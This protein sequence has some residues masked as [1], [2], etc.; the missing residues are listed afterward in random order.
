MN[1]LLQ[2]QLGINS[3]ARA[4]ALRALFLVLPLLALADI[5]GAQ[6]AQVPLTSRSLPPPPPNVMVTIDDSG[7]ML[8]DAMPEGAFSVNGK[9]VTLLGEYVIAFPGDPLKN[10]AG[11]RVVSAITTDT[12]TSPAPVFQKQYRSPQVNS[13]WYDPSVLYLPWVGPDGVNRLPP[14]DPA[15]APYNPATTAALNLTKTV[16]LGSAST[17]KVGEWCKELGKCSNKLGNLSFNPGLYYILTPG[18][19]PNNAASYT[20]YNINSTVAAAKV[21]PRAATRTDCQTNAGECSQAEERQNF[22][23]WFTYYRTRELLTKGAVSDTLASFVDKIRAGWAQINMTNDPNGTRRVQADVKFLDGGANS[24]LS[25]MLGNIQTYQSDGRT[26][27]RVAMDEVGAYFQS[28]DE[29]NPWLT[30]PGDASSGSLECRRAMNVLMTD[31]YY[32]D[33]NFSSPNVDGE[34]GPWHGDPSATETTASNPL[35]KS[36]MR[37]VKAV[38]YQD[39]YSSTLADVAMKY[40]VEDLR[41]D[42]AN[43]VMPVAGDIAYWQHLNQYTVGLGVKGTL[44]ASTPA[45]KKATLAAIMAGSLSWPNPDDGDPQKIDDMWHAAVNTGGDFYSVRNAPELANALV[46][47]INGAVEPPASEAGVAVSS[48]SL[49]T[50]S[51]KLVP[52][53]TGTAWTGDLAAYA[54]DTK[55]VFPTTHTWLASAGV[56]LAAER[57][58]YTWDGTKSIEFKSVPS[59]GAVQTEVGATT[60]TDYIRG[61]ASNEGIGPTSYRRRNG[62]LLGDF[63]NSPPVYVKDLV[64]LGYEKFDTSYTEYLKQKGARATPLVFLGGNAGMLHVFSGGSSSTDGKE[65]YGYLPKDGLKNLKII[66][67]TNYGTASNF[68]QFFVDGPLVET[69]AMIATRRYPTAAWSN[70]VL[71]SM[72]A[73]GTGLF[74]LHVDTLSP[75][76]LN[77]ETLLWE[78]SKADITNLGYV[79]SP[80]VAGKLRGAGGWVGLVGNGAFSDSGTASL[81]VLDLATGA[82]KQELVVDATGGNGLMGV[83]LLHNVSNEVVAAYAGDLKGNVWRFDFDADGVGAIGFGK[84]A[85]FT[86]TGS[87]GA[88]PITAAPQWVRNTA[89]PGRVVVFGTGKLMTTADAVDGQKQTLYGVLDPTPEGASS[90]TSVSPFRGLTNVRTVLAPRTA[91]TDARTNPNVATSYY[92]ITG[93]PIDWATQKGWYMDL[94]FPNDQGPAFQREIYPVLILQGSY[95]FFQTLVPAEDAADCDTANGA[96]YNYLLNAST[97]LPSTSPVLDTDNSGTVDDKDLAGVGGFSTGADG[98][99]KVVEAKSACTTEPCEPDTRC[100]PGTTAMR[101]ESSTGS[102]FMCVPNQPSIVKDRIWRRIVTPPL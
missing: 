72:G 7:S 5:A 102:Q 61:D 21:F 99:D 95:A 47:A 79:F 81:L 46:E 74:A 69:D 68:H 40:F 73:G 1:K 30:V 101:D 83:T 77:A 93:S 59:M 94:P 91:A 31:G 24:H 45:A 51:L 88:Q 66:A 49:V 35:N 8:S 3:G 28:S 98:S 55:G 96:G 70:L 10:L 63:V 54:M 15:A 4:R 42:I 89:G 12:K 22:A 65:L 86:A 43:K 100:P 25:S 62:K 36:P 80:I 92:D 19:D 17:P 33:E 78:K 23:N 41:K 34:N 32:N 52:W 60:L 14:S 48:N 87:G 29:N 71:G 53:F 13:I 67:K 97:G 57:N 39:S 37:Y 20:T 26:P 18:A 75:T 44:D 84:T 2:S 9:E 85:L 11:G 6:P 76:T 50:G 82:V 38:P 27:L 56:G 90:V 58:L 16:T 64:N